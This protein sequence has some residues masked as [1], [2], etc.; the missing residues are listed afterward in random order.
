MRLGSVESPAPP[1]ARRAASGDLAST[2]A[3]HATS[4]PAIAVPR[5]RTVWHALCAVSEPMDTDFEQD[6]KPALAARATQ[7][8]DYVF[9]VI[10][11]LIGLEIFLELAAARDA[12]AFKRLVDTISFPFL[13]PFRSL[14]RDPAIGDSRIMFSY[15]AALIVW[16]LIHFGLR[17]L[18]RLIGRKRSPAEL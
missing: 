5:S 8:L 9:F 13:A 12:N 11:A 15:V 17:G 3:R 10:Y 18:F 4:T 14:F 16:I 1:V 6:K 2:E 7:I